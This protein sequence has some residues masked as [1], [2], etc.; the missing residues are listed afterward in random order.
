MDL[1]SNELE[2]PIAMPLS[3]GIIGISS[4]SSSITSQKLPLPDVIVEQKKPKGGSGEKGLSSLPKSHLPNLK[5]ISAGHR[6][7]EEIRTACH[8]E[9][10]NAHATIS[11]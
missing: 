7:P 4:Y 1:I 8:A 2:L 9:V 5:K 3:F 10:D 11:F 6:T